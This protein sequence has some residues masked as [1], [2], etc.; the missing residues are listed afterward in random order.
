MGVLGQ[1]FLYKNYQMLL[2]YPPVA[3]KNIEVLLENQ[4]YYCLAFFKDSI[5]KVLDLNHN[6][7]TWL[8]GKINLLRPFLYL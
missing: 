4:E 5:Y 8:F 3:R 6:S 1:Y 2:Y 7:L